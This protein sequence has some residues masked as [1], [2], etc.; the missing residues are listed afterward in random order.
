MQRAG[1]RG[2][3]DADVASISDA[4]PLE[5]IAVEFHLPVGGTEHAAVVVPAVAAEGITVVVHSEGSGCSAA[6]THP[7]VDIKGGGRIGFVDAHVARCAD[8]ELVVGHRGEVGILRV[9]PDETAS[10]IRLGSL[11]SGKARL[12]FGHVGQAAGHGRIGAAAAVCATAAHRR[13]APVTEITP[14]AAD[15]RPTA[16]AIDL[17]A[18]DGRMSVVGGIV[19]AAANECMIRQRG[20]RIARA[21]HDGGIETEVGVPLSGANER[22]LPERSVVGAAHHCG[23][24]ARITTVARA[25]ERVVA[26]HLVDGALGAA[27]G[28]SHAGKVP[29]GIVVVS[30][31]QVRR[32]A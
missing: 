19:L 17:A 4:H 28:N 22:E 18:A 1:G 8:E 13:I 6:G 12:A 15:G 21:R 29:G 2:R 9:G 14:A 25:D 10:V 30:A 5:R 26:G 23:E 32:T 24:V 27:A 31:H 16:G 11:S 3:A 7:A 20:D